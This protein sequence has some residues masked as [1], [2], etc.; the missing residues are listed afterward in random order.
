MITKNDVQLP[1]FSRAKYNG[2]THME[3]TPYKKI[4]IVLVFMTYSSMHRFYGKK[5]IIHFPI[6]K[7]SNLRKAFPFYTLH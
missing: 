3:T 1:V 2:L 7:T 6:I 4:L 5:A